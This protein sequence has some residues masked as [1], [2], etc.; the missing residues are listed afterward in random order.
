M[1]RKSE[2]LDSASQ[3]TADMIESATETLSL[4]FESQS[5]LSMEEYKSLSKVVTA[6]PLRLYVE[7][8]SEGKSSSSVVQMLL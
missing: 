3:A 6:F 8:A 7:N 2:V 5:F 4:Q 1:K